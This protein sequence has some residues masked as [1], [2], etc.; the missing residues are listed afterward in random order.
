MALTKN[1]SRPPVLTIDGPSGAGKGAVSAAVARRLG[2]NALDSGAV[3]RS[4]ALA[5]LER[6]VA[7]DDEQALV[8]LTRNVDLT[9]R[10]GSDGIGVFLGDREVGGSLRT[11][12]VSVMASRVA[13]I[14]AVRAALLELQ[15]AYRVMPGLVA[16]GRDMGTI[17]FPDAE[18]KVF[19]EASVEERAKRRYNQL[20]EKGESV[21][22]S[23]LF[24]DMQARDRR[25]RER[26]VAPTVPAADAAVVDSTHLSLDEVIGHVVGLARERFGDQVPKDENQ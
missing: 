2:W 3:Y 6:G 10:A 22:L 14:P 25:D 19:L 24:R 4:V 20:K 16:D 7:A 15:R 11:E 1:E 8:E 23:R 26:S 9:F 13:A 21:I 12:E 18:L 5:A 17:V